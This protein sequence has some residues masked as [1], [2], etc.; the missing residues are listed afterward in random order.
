MSLLSDFARG[1]G[2]GRQVTPS[3][4]RQHFEA[5]L[6]GQAPDPS[7]LSLSYSSYIVIRQSMISRLYSG[8]LSVGVRWGIRVGN[9][10]AIAIYLTLFALT[11]LLDF[12]SA[13]AGRIKF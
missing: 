8:P 9:N 6:A 2:I 10:P 1:F 5:S 3:R 7:G 4:V 13:L 12:V 11:F